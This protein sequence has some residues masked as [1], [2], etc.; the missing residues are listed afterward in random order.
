MSEIVIGKPSLQSAN[1]L[2]R[3]TTKINQDGRIFPVFIEVED[4]WSRYLTPERAD[5][6]VYLVLPVA[7]RKG[8]NIRTK[9]PVTEMMLN[10]INKILI[11]NL[12]K[13]DDRL[14]L[15]QI[16]APSENELIGGTRCGTAVSLGVDSTYT[17]MKYNDGKNTPMSIDTLFITSNNA[18]LWSEI[19]STDDLYSWKEKKLSMFARYEAFA[20]ECNLPLVIAFSNYH[21]YVCVF[22]KIKHV[23]THN[24]TTMAHVLSLKKLWKSY[25]FAAT[26]GGLFVFDLMNNSVKDTCHHELLSMFVLTTPDFSCFSGGDVESRIEKTLKLTE[27]PLAR[28]F[29]HPCF[30]SM[31]KNCSRASCKKCNRALLTL[32]YYGKLDSM[33]DIYDIDYYKSH[34]VEFLEALVQNKDKKLYAELYTMYKKRFPDKIQIIETTQI[35]QPED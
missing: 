13:G 15:I 16:Y 1:G 8:Y 24:Y 23:M 5:A 33:S 9:V 26:D 35:K 29:L 25:F 21:K 18:E 6:F 22:N 3:M 7:L 17:I 20:K 19:S 4:K 30:K 31:E 28:K 2:C 10:K 11:P 12:V 32:D 34:K 14:S 27:Y